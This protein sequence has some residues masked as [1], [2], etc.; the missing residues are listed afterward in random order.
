MKKDDD[1][2]ATVTIDNQSFCTSEPGVFQDE[3]GNLPASVAKY[4]QYSTKAKRFYTCCGK[5]NVITWK[6]Y[7]NGDL[8]VDHVG[9]FGKATMRNSYSDCVD[10]AKDYDPSA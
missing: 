3:Y 9:P 10:S 5:G 4:Q 6:K 7:D 8:V 2:W 1:S